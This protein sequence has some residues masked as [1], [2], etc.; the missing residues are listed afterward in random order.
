MLF[1]KLSKSAMAL[2]LALSVACPMVT[3]AEEVNVPVASVEQPTVEA[4][5][6][7]QTE[8]TEVASKP[9]ISVSAADHNP[10]KYKNG[11]IAKEQ[12]ELTI[13]HDKAFTYSIGWVEEDKYSAPTNLEEK[14]ESQTTDTPVMLVL[15]GNESGSPVKYHISAV[16]DGQDEANQNTFD[17]VVDLPSKVSGGKQILA[18]TTEAL[19]NELSFTKAVDANNVDVNSKVE[20]TFKEEVTFTGNG[21]PILEST[22]DLLEISFVKDPSGTPVKVEYKAEWDSSTRKITLIPTAPLEKLKQY[23]ISIK[24][25]LVQDIDKN[26]NE[27]FDKT[28]TT[29]DDTNGP[30]VTSVEPNVSVP[31]PITVQPKLTFSEPLFTSSGIALDSNNV[32]KLFQLVNSNNELVSYDAT[33]NPV[34]YTVTLFPSTDLVPGQHY[35]IKL[36]SGKVFDSAGNPNG[37]SAVTFVTLADETPLTA[38]FDPLPGATNVD[39]T[40]SPKITFSEKVY[41][42]DG[43]TPLNQN[44]L[45]TISSL[46]TLK[47][48]SNQIVTS[49]ASYNASTRVLTIDPETDLAYSTSYFLTLEGNKVRD[50]LNAAVAEQKISFTT[51]SDNVSPT[52]TSS[53]ETNPPTPVGLNDN[54]VLTF[55]EPITIRTTP[56]SY[57][58]FTNTTNNK[59]VPFMLIPDSNNKLTIDPTNSLEAGKNYS[60]TVHENLVR[61]LANNPNQ[62]R[63]FSFTSTNN[64]ALAPIASFYPSNNATGISLSDVMTITFNEEVALTDSPTLP[65]PNAVNLFYLTDNSGNKVSCTYTYDSTNYRLL[66]RPSQL[67][68]SNM[69][70]YLNLADKVVQD[71]AGNRTS[72]GS[73]SFT[74]INDTTAPY[75]TIYPYSGYSSYPV[76]GNLRVTFSEPVYLSSGADISYSNASSIFTLRD[77]STGSYISSYSL[78]YNSSTYELTIDPTVNLKNNTSYT[79][80]VIQNAVRDSSNNYVSQTASSFTTATDANPPTIVFS[81][82]SGSTGNAVTTNITLSFSEPVTLQSADYA[83]YI[84]LRENGKTVNL[85]FNGSWNSS[86]QQLV[87]DPTSDLL[88]NRTYYVTVTAGFVKDSTNNPNAAAVAYFSTQNDY[89]APTFTAYPTSGTTGVSLTSDLSITVSEAFTLYDGTEVTSQN[90]SGIV[91]LVDSRNKTV[92]TTVTYS[93]ANRTLTI[94]PVPILRSNE[95]YRIVIASSK[96][97]DLAGNANS[98]FTSTFRTVSYGLPYISSDITNGQTNVAVSRPFQISFSENVFLSDGSSITNSNVGKL[99]TF[100]D[101]AGKNV[102]FSATWNA[103]HLMITVEPKGKLQPS[104]YYYITIEAGAV[105]NAGGAKNTLFSLSFSTV[106]N[107]DLPTAVSAPENGEEDVPLDTEIYIQFSKPVLLANGSKLTDQNADSLVQLKNSSGVL[108]KY[109]ADWDEEDVILT[110]TPTVR[111]KKNDAYTIYLP[112]GA[113]KDE[114]G[115]PVQSYTASFYSVKD[116]GLVEI[117]SNPMNGDEDVATDEPLYVVFGESVTLKNNVKITSSNLSSVISVYDESMKKLN[118]KFEWDSSKNSVKITPVTTLKPNSTYSIVLEAGKVYNRLKKT[119]AGYIVTFKTSTEDT[120]P[121]VTT[122]P[123]DGDKNVSVKNN[124]EVVFKEPV[125]LTNGTELSSDNVAKL[126]KVVDENGKAV[127][128]KFKWI[129]SSQK[130]ILDPK[131]NLKKNHTYTI[132]MEAGVVSD[133]SGNVNEEYT[134]QFTTAKK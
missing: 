72:G 106:N 34:L 120:P 84:T 97:K 128:C 57:I 60:V 15:A 47:N 85:P 92:E 12:I 125:T 116:K 88:P 76:E 81:P 18:V 44:D 99:L 70:Y 71:R 87:L 79:L 4:S 115:N 30:T 31:L 56:S 53:T 133:L 11:A 49:T 29:A 105:Q 33:Y 75:A 51:R 131:I 61:D 39:P 7:I 82:Y 32:D 114:S 66:I 58:T 62:Q 107:T 101:S 123:D 55:S 80:T 42:I 77:N 134:A 69:K 1:G 113:V 96:I 9:Q 17:I 86:T 78:S 28:F 50:Q 126:V 13:Q 104:T 10:K 27:L 65:G 38:T 36:L 112:E 63:I 64:D 121:G 19:I 94:N 132:F 83:S 14:V 54:I 35:A 6:Q 21:G 98:S 43:K 41:L 95:E 22:L 90:A 48:S 124:I 119:N 110:L 103:D 3:N 73:I 46:Y 20:I 129:A 40:V 127:A 130:I 118:V 52:F 68:R 93:A 74:T 26:V 122:N 5:N 102:P 67:L 16:E 91:S 24:Q 100:K 23:K 109:K 8:Q 89:Y 37:P 59:A 25:G 111:L 2:I 45:P 117:L 108:V